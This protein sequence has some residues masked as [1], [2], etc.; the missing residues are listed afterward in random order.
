[1]GSLGDDGDEG[2]GGEIVWAWRSYRV[3]MRRQFLSL[4]KRRSMTFLRRY[5]RLSRG[6]GAGAQRLEG[7]TALAPMLAM[8]LE[9]T[10]N[11]VVSPPWERPSA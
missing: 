11:L 5:A 9:S 3:A 1:M 7:L 4:P 6:S 10:W 8:M 2:D